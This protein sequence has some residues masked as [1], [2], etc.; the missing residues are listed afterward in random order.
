MKPREMSPIQETVTVGKPASM[1]FRALTDAD[2]VA[3]WFAEDAY[4]ELV[5]GGRY[6]V[7]GRQGWK[8]G[9]VSSLI[10]DRRLVISWPVEIGDAQEEQTTIDFSLE[11]RGEKTVVTMSHSGLRND[12]AWGNVYRE[13]KEGW[14]EKLA[15]FGRFV[16]GSYKGKPRNDMP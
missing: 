3:S 16:E 13:L 6:E 2:E 7:L 11:P 8:H 10:E 12:E 14:T 4:I 9:R 5:E 1:V 15:T